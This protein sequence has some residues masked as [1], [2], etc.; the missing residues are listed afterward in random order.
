MHLYVFICILYA[1]TCIY[2]HLYAFICILYIYMHLYAFTLCILC[3]YSNLYAFKFTCLVSYIFVRNIYVYFTLFDTYSMHIC[4][5]FRY[6]CRIPIPHNGG[7]LRPP[8]QQWGG[9]LRR[10]PHCCGIHYGGWG[11]GRHSENICKYALN[12]YQIM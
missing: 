11:C 6:V 12:M 5:C 8:P 1:F 3:I 10:P 7:G 2:I 4:I 9:R